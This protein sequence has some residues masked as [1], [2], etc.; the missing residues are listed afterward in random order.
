[1]QKKA[2]SLIELLIVIMIIGIVYTFVVGNFNRVVQQRT[3]LNL[4]NLKEYL[5][6]LKYEKSAKLLCLDD[7]SSCEIRIDGKVFNTLDD[8]LNE[9][10]RT[11]RYDFL[12]GYTEKEQEVYFNTDDIE[13]DVCFSYEVDNMGVGSQVLVEFGE[14]FYD[15]SSYFTKTKVYNSIGE[16]QDAREDLMREARQ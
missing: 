7:C 16:A 6:A 4:E 14:K 2:F 15:Y 5:T 8:F 9:N 12:Y 1:M 10:V 13:E 3:K 11:Y